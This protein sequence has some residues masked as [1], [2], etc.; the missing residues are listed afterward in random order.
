MDGPEI[1]FSQPHVLRLSITSDPDGEEVEPQRVYEM[2]TPEAQEAADLLAIQ[3][4]LTF[5]W[6]ALD[7]IQDLPSDNREFTDLVT[8]ALW[9]SAL[10]AYARCFGTGKRAKLTEDDVLRTPQGELMVRFHRDMVS[11][12]NKHIAH[13][14]NAMEVI[15]IGAMVGRL[16]ATDDEGVTGMAAVFSAEWAVNSRTLATLGQL[17]DEL[18]AA[19]MSRT[20]E[21]TPAVVEAARAAGVVVVKTW[22]ELTY[23][24]DEVD[25]GVPRD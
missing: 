2:Q 16:K 24:R 19:V 18:L 23:Q 21:H 15:K 25:P 4:D 6:E 1:A 3:R 22:P 7:L 11:M 13:S 17:A 10:V 12:R 20:E 8:R 5:V 9:T 14:V